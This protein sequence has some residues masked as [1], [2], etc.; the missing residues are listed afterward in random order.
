MFYSTVHWLIND[1]RLLLPS[2]SLRIEELCVQS[3]TAKTSN[4]QWQFSILLEWQVGHVDIVQHDPLTTVK[5]WRIY[6][7]EL[8][9]SALKPLYNLQNANKINRICRVVQ[10]LTS[11]WGFWFRHHVC[12]KCEGDRGGW[13]AQVELKHNNLYLRG[14]KAQCVRN[15][16]ST[17]GFNG[18]WLSVQDTA[19][20]SST[21]SHAPC[22]D[23][24]SSQTRATIHRQ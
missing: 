17:A 22:M 3:H 24:S 14:G 7:F 15:D 4:C 21:E 23:D 6:S 11:P 20:R 16:K 12:W 9:L 10:K 2:M 8:Y 18:N 13:I 1:F 5:R 19:W